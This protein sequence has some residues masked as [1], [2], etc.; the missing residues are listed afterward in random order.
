MWGN[1]NRT[2][3]GLRQEWSVCLDKGKKELGTNIGRKIQRTSLRAL[4]L[5]QPGKHPGVNAHS[6]GC[7]PNPAQ[8]GHG[9]LRWTGMGCGGKRSRQFSNKPKTSFRFHSTENSWKL[10]MW[11]TVLKHGSQAVC[12]MSHS[13][14]RRGENVSRERWQSAFRR[15]CKNAQWPWAGWRGGTGLCGAEHWM[16]CFLGLSNQPESTACRI[17]E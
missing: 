17:W 14:F 7:R 12:L 4:G 5:R 1:T 10:F 3:Q 16:N 2:C 9:L 15:L 11:V 6:S 8:N 13:H